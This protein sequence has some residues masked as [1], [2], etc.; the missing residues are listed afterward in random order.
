MR[1]PLPA[2]R[3]MKVDA[4]VDHT[5][6]NTRPQHNPGNLVART[7]TSRRREILDPRNARPPALRVGAQNDTPP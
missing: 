4:A 5:R 2:T 7:R 1:D 6:L 3:L